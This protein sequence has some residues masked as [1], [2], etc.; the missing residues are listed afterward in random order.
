MPFRGWPA[1]ALEFFD[2][3]EADNSKTFWE[4]NKATYQRCVRGPT[5]Q[6]LEELAPEFGPGKLFRPYR[7]V[8]FSKDKSPYK[9]NIAAMVGETGYLS[10]SAGGL[11]VGSGMYHMA[12]DQLDRYR[13]ALDDEGTGGELDALAAALGR[14]GMELIA[15]DAL[16]TVPRGYAK[17]HPRADLLRRKGLAA[18][19]HFEP[20]AWL[21]T[22]KART[23]VADTLRAT[24]PLRAWLAANVGP[25]TALPST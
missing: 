18:I 1:E 20:A 5:E 10:L 7:D 23:R 22:A 3:L 4:A 17:D 13:R 25:T 21:G 12:P 6:L 15:H 2:G 11:E 8:R 24:A 14:R 9:T 16:K 19:R